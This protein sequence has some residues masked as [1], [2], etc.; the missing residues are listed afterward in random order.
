MAELNYTDFAMLDDAS[1][2]SIDEKD[3]IASNPQANEDL[4]DDTDADMTSLSSSRGESERMRTFWSVRRSRS[5]YL[6][7]LSHSRLDSK[8]LGVGDCQCPVP[9]MVDETR[10]RALLGERYTLPVVD[11]REEAERGYVTPVLRNREPLDGVEPLC[12]ASSPASPARSSS[13]SSLTADRLS[14]DCYTG[15]CPSSCTPDATATPV[16]PCAATTI[17]ESTRAGECGGYAEEVAAAMCTDS[18]SV[19]QQKQQ[20]QHQHQQQQ[21]DQEQQKKAQ[22]QQDQ[23]HTARSMQSSAHRVQEAVSRLCAQLNGVDAVEY[24]SQRTDT[25]SVGH[26]YTEPS[27][28]VERQPREGKNDGERTSEQL[29]AYPSA[30]VAVRRSA[31]TELPSGIPRKVGNERKMAG[32]FFYE[33]IGSPKHIAAPMV[34]LS[35][36]PFR[37]LV[38][39]HGADLVYTPMINSNLW[40]H[41]GRYRQVNWHT[42]PADHPLFIQ[43]CGNDPCNLLRA[44]L[45]VQHLGESID[46]NLGCPQRIARRGFY[47]AFLYEEP[48][49][50]FDM[51][52]MLHDY[53]DVPIT[54]KIRV[55]DQGEEATIAYAKML[56][57]AGCQLLCVHGRTRTQKG[58]NEVPPDWA[59]VRKIREAISIPMF[60]NGGIDTH[61]DI[62]PALRLTGVDGC[63]SSR[64]LLRNPAIFEANPPSALDLAEE[65]LDLAEKYQ[66]ATQAAMRGH[67]FNILQGITEQQ[68]DVR[69]AL[70]VAKTIGQFRSHV[71]ELRKREADGTTCLV[72]VLSEKRQLKVQ[73][74]AQRRLLDQQ[75]ATEAVAGESMSSLFGDEDD[76]Y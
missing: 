35:E 66:C 7:L 76:T 17:E 69:E 57:R 21:K 56:E 45:S 20:H 1:A 16:P 30:S 34:Q 70:T 63:M 73:A 60:V 67:V 72:A 8:F 55:L 50:V 53:L 49:L 37:L 40:Q 25:S 41:N 28:G 44:A 15:A 29:R 31:A 65:Y 24:R 10:L 4:D 3:L 68:V 32:Y 47:G 11:G 38:L 58:H 43:F 51:V 59:L 33:S 2:F 71:A 62:E 75:L 42:C 18:G 13:E 26:D 54:C 5:E 48:Q 19:S 46:L 12:C 9:A 14:N 61:E 74:R 52:R 6:K 36:L 39:R 23:C 27:G 22:E 64:G